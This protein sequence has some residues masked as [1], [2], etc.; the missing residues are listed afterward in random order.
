M[1]YYTTG[2]DLSK[3]LGATKI[4]GGAKGGSS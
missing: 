1:N 2:V 3:L 4:L